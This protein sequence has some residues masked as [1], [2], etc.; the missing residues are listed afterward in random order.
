MEERNRIRK[1]VRKHRHH[2]P[3]SLGRRRSSRERKEEGGDNEEEEGDRR[4]EVRGGG[5]LGVKEKEGV[6]WLYIYI[7]VKITTKYP[8]IHSELYF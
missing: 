1:G 5:S 6:E 2:S 7:Y 8:I 3:A 4:R